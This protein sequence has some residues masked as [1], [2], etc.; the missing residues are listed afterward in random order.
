MLG[1]GQPPLVL[2]TASPLYVHPGHPE[3]IGGLP[4]RAHGILSQNPETFYFQTA[5][6]SFMVRYTQRDC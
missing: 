4:Q 1:L 5:S 3:H 6:K 2:N